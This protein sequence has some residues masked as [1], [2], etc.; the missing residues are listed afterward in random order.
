MFSIF[1]KDPFV[2]L[3]TF[4][5]VSG[6][7]ASLSFLFT[8]SI[9][10]ILER[11]NL[12]E[13]FVGSS[14]LAIGTSL[15]ETINA[16]TAGFYDRK[17]GSSQTQNG[18]QFDMPFSLNSL[19][20]LTGANLVQIVFLAIV[21]L[22]IWKRAY[23]R[24]KDQI[25]CKK[26]ITSVFQGKLF[27]WTISTIELALLGIFFIFSS[28]SKEINIFGYNLIPF[29]YLA[30]WVLYLIFSKKSSPTTALP[31]NFSA[32][33]P[34]Y[35]NIFQK[36]SSFNFSIVFLL[37]FA[38]FAILAFVNFQ[39]VSKFEKV[40]KIDKNIGLGTILSLVT[41]LP[42]F[43]S[44]FFLFQ[45]KC[46]DAA[47]SGFL[48]SALF[49]LMLPALTQLI[50]GGWLFESIGTGKEQIPL[51][52]WIFTILLINICFV[53]GFYINKKGTFIKGI[54]SIYWNIN[55]SFAIVLLYIALALIAS[56]LAFS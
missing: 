53:T 7:I 51:V 11:F 38:A 25:E 14:L 52:F 29:L 3:F 45:S 33:P 40:L 37:I 2:L 32:L 56:S 44:F 4:L 47:C 1:D 17:D 22:Y 20:N 31:T 13:K 48:G 30:V 46:Y 19:Y 36:L 26:F 21:T 49:N 16:I 28:F 12:S 9:K 24:K 54:K 10:N 39:L 42:E 5:V 55:W 23:K 15:S 18:Q 34:K 50:K 35:K 43:S 8:E 41:S 27:L 6:G